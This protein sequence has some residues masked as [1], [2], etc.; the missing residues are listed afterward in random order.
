MNSNKVKKSEETKN[1]IYKGAIDLFER[2]GFEQTTIKDLTR[3][4][5]ISQGI[6]YYHFK[7]KDDVLIHYFR[8][9]HVETSKRVEGVLA[10]NKS[11]GVKVLSVIEVNMGLLKEHQNITRD[12]INTTSNLSHPLSPFG[13]DLGACQQNAIQM[14][15]HALL[16]EH[17]PGEYLDS[18][19]FL[20]WLY[21]LALCLCWAND[22]SKNADNTEKLLRTTFPLTRKLIA[23]TKIKIGQKMLIKIAHLLRSILVNWDEES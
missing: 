1:Y 12:L 2:K 4:L 8:Q 7:S 13:P 18:I 10:S 6:L 15:R 19:A 11:S 3:E 21:H 5:G 20:Y 9:L 23:L 14:F 17:K 22:K 16:Q